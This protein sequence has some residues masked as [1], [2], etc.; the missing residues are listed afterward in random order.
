MAVDFSKTLVVGVS[1]RALFDLEPDAQLFRE[2]GLDAYFAH[3]RENE[4]LPLPKGSAFSLIRDLLE[5]GKEATTDLKQPAIAVVVVSGHHPDISLRVMSS[6]AHYGLDIT[7]AA[8][9][10]GAATGPYLTAFGAKLLLSRSKEDAQQAVDAGLAAAILY[11]LPKDYQH[12][13]WDGTLRIAFDGDAVIFSDECELF[14]KTHGLDR[15]QESEAKKALIPIPPGP[16]GEFLVALHAIRQIRPSSVRIALVTARN[17]PAHERALRTL[18]S[19]GVGV[20]EAFFLGG[21]PKANFLKSFRPAIFFDDQDI[22]LA[23][24]ASL[25]PVALVPYRTCQVPEI[26]K[27]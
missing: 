13:E 21:L 6:A 16:F 5:L 9:T 26:V 19:W 23:P 7:R 12:P 22:H 3:Q 24:A 25:C 11:N 2:K 17:A 15:Y 10:G 20:D 27:D 14:Y 18:R 8:F 4:S 1:A